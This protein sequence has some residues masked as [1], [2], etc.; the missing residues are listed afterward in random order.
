[1]EEL[2]A[3]VQQSPDDVPCQIKL[4]EAL[5]YLGFEEEALPHYQRAVAVEPDYPWALSALGHALAERGENAAA[6]SYFQR[7]LEAYP[8]H[9]YSR[10][11]L[12]EV[13]AAQEQWDTAVEHYQ[14]FVSRH[15]EDVQARLDFVDVL[16]RQGRNADVANQLRI[17]VRRSP[18]D[19][20][21]R[22]R[23]ARLLAASPDDQVREP[24]EALA[25]ARRAAKLVGIE[26]VVRQ[27]RRRDATVD[28][29]AARALDVL[30]MAYAA[31]GSFDLAKKTA[32]LAMRAAELVGQTERKA[33]IFRRF[34]LYEQ[35]KPYR[36]PSPRRLGEKEVRDC[37]V[38]LGVH[39]S[40]GVH[41]RRGL[42]VRVRVLG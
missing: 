41:S 26:T 39:S 3:A 14:Y 30:A 5:D 21:L 7:A 38:D 37:E 20:E 25:S 19:V 4:G 12:A 13:S 31:N 40:L 17:G 15:P 11:R 24:E 1:M 8:E 16:S 34:K 28:P 35:Q 9:S 29:I 36:D 18:D 23:L 33:G 42:C 10:R 6:A 27:V 32:E 22:L 2:T